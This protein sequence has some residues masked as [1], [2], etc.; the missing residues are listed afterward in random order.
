[1]KGDVMER[2]KR[3]REKGGTIVPRPK[4]K[5]VCA[6]AEINF[7]FSSFMHSVSEFETSK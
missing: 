2:E 7:R 4:Q 3:G 6:T 1:M 5:F